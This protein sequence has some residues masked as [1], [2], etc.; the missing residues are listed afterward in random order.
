MHTLEHRKSL[1]KVYRKKLSRQLWTSNSFLL[2]LLDISWYFRLNILVFI[3]KQD[4]FNKVLHSFLN[5]NPVLLQWQ[6]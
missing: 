5:L 6:Q 1:V 3:L 4:Q 2:D